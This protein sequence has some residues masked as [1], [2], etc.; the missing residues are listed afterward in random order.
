MNRVFNSDLRFEGIMFGKSLLIGMSG[1]QPS[2]VISQSWI[3]PANVEVPHPSEVEIDRFMESL[4]FAALSHS[5]YGWQR[6]ADASP[7]WT[8][9]QTIS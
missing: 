9:G 7:F 3:R 2:I 4:G 1:Q 6:E 8:R 5:Y